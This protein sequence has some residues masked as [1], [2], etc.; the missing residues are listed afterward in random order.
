[1]EKN[2]EILEASATCFFR[3]GLKKTTMTDV[4]NAAGVSRQTLYNLYPNREVLVEE[5]IVFLMDKALV[6]IQNIW[7]TQDNLADKI[8]T[9]FKLGPISWYDSIQ[10]D[11]D[12]A[13]ILEGGS[14]V[15]SPIALRVHEAWVGAIAE[16]FKKSFAADRVEPLA[17]FFFNTSKNAKYGSKDRNQF[18]ERLA[19]LKE[20]IL[21]A[22]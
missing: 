1:M 21:N 4:A 16:E 12:A 7:A 9:Y 5:T 19:V 15:F 6:E 13:E 22:A 17:D 11:P 18:M 3:Y 14:E 2:A 8:D 20:M 10:A